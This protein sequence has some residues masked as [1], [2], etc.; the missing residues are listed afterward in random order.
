MDILRRQLAPISSAAWEEIDGQAI[1]VLRSHLSARRVVDVEGPK[2]WDYAAEALGR[3]DVPDG[4]KAGVNYGIHQVQPLVEARIPFEL[5]IWELDNAIRGAA[6]IDL[7]PVE[8]A[9]VKIAQFEE[10]AI[11]YGF[12]AGDIAGLKASSPYKALNLTP[13]REKAV[14][15]LSGGVAQFMEASVEGPYA[16]VAGPAMWSFLSS[17]GKGYPL[18][19]QL[20]N[21][22]GGPIVLGPSVKD[23]FL[24]STRGGDMSLILGQDLSIGYLSHDAIK[25][26]LYLTE[27]FTFRVVDPAAVMPLAWK[28]K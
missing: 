8:D 18:R 6:D 15:V 25:V 16:L 5:N 4:Q 26:K 1:R 14:E 9:A 2:G 23:G 12:K 19:K 24:L 21:L 10:S 27:S 17:A 22:L 11:Y 20:E 3:L 28:T 7:E 13:D